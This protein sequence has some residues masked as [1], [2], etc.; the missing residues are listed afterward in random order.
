MEI[1]LSLFKTIQI[2]LLDWYQQVKRDLPWRRTQNPYFIWVSEVMLQQTQVDTVIPYYERFTE[3]FPTM[4]ALAHANEEEVLKYWEGLGY[5]SRARNLQAGVREVVEQY[6]SEVPRTRS[7]ILN[8]KGIGPYTA[9]AVLSIAYNLPE[10][11]VDGNVMRVLSRLFLISEDITKPKT[12]KIFEDLLYQLIPSES[13]SDFNQALMELG[14]LVCRPKQPQCEACPLQSCCVAHSKSVETQFPVK[15]RK[16]TKKNL[17]YQVFVLQ[18]PTGD[19]LVHQRPSEGLL[20][21]MW[22]FPMLEADS[23]DLE[24]CH[25]FFKEELKLADPIHI[26]RIGQPIIHVFSHLKWEL[27]VWQAKTHQLVEELPVSYKWVSKE[28]LEELPF[29]VAHQNVWSAS[30]QREYEQ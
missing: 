27:T 15:T 8:I 4:E 9:G 19:Y 5:Y 3:R 22:E 11:A 24:K 17:G 2:Q 7:E 21:N 16:V 10:P 25:I 26:E 29:P 13:A 30:E 23:L 1:N 28:R 18:N 20:A 12:R 14:A 6:G